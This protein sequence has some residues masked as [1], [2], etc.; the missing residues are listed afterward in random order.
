MKAKLP[1]KQ[2]DTN[3]RVESGYDI[4]MQMYPQRANI[5]QGL[6]RFVLWQWEPYQVPTVKLKPSIDTISPVVVYMV[7]KKHSG[8]ADQL[9]LASG[10]SE[11][12]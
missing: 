6:D 7:E 5:P 1:K 12:A 3:S 8:K 2:D 9:T 11:H 4:H 10:G